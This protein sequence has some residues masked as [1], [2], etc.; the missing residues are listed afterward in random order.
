MMSWVGIV[1]LVGVIVELPTLLVTIL[2][3]ACSERF[4]A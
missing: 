1:A 4:R 2:A 3:R